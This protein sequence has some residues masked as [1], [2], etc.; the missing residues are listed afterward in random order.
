MSTISSEGQPRPS[1]VLTDIHKEVFKEKVLRILAILLII[2]CPLVLLCCFKVV[3]QYKR[4][5][6]LRFGRVRDVSPAGP[7]IIWT[8]PCTDSVILIDLRTRA[9]NIPPQQIL[10]RDFVTVALDAVVYFHVTNPIHCLLN[11]QSHEQATE[12]LA[13]S[14]LRNRVGL[15]TLADLLTIREMISQEVLMEIEKAAAEWGVHIERVAIKNV[16]LPQELQKAMAAEAEGKRLAKAKIIEAE[17]EIKTA[18]NLKEASKII[19]E[20]PQIMLLRYLQTLNFIASQQKTSIFFP[21]PLQIPDPSG[22]ST[23]S[24]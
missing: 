1:I 22:S 11:I 13:I 8:V 5:V 7:G 9:L 24:V 12:M 14:I 3:K 6:I 10:T 4:A 19:M 23:S 16:V 20:N 17:G 21:F 15:H 2:L 18:E